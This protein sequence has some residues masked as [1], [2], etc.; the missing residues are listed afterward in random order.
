MKVKGRAAERCA[1]A[2]PESRERLRWAEGSKGKQASLRKCG[3]DMA[4]EVQ[5]MER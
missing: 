2:M 5:S 1:S 3:E 4:R